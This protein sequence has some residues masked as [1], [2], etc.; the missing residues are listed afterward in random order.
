MD[1]ATLEQRSNRLAHA[2]RGARGFEAGDRVALLARNRME[3]VEVLVGASR[4]PWSTSG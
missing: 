4:R 3:V 2:L 1:Y